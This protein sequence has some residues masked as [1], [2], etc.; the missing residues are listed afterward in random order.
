MKFPSFLFAFL[1][2]LALGAHA[3]TYT[4]I[5]GNWTGLWSSDSGTSNRFFI[6]VY[7]SG[8]SYAGALDNLDTG[9]N[10]WP[11]S[12]I[13]FTAPSVVNMTF[14][15]MGYSYTGVVNGAFTQ[16]SGNWIQGQQTWPITFIRNPGVND[17]LACTNIDA[18]GSLPYRLFVPS[19][20]TGTQSYPLILFLHGRG[21]RG[22]D[23]TNQLCG[24]TGEL[25]LVFNENQASHPSFVAAPQCPSDTEWTNS[26]MHQQ[27]LDL[28]TSLKSQ[29]NIDSNRVYITGLSMGGN[30]TWHL[31]SH[32]TSLFASGVPMSGETY[33][34][35]PDSVLPVPVWVFH[36]LSD[37]TVA[38]TNSQVMVSGM[39]ALGGSPIYT[40]YQYGGHSIW[41][42]SYATPLL[43]EW[44]LSQ[45]RGAV[46]SNN[47]APFLQ[48][49]YPY[50]GL[51]Y[52]TS[53][54]NL[55]LNGTAG[56]SLAGV[57]QIGWT[58]NRT[59]SG[60]AIGTTNWSAPNVSL[61]TG[62][63]LITVI[64]TGASWVTQ[65]YGQ[66]TFNS[67]IW[68]YQGP[69]LSL[70]ASNGIATLTWTGGSPPYYL[71]QCTNLAFGQW[72]TLSTNSSSS[73]Q[74]GLSSSPVF[75]RVRCQ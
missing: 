39:R 38:V 75:F 23:N 70:R 73:A 72:Q 41:S 36:S 17:F 31:L 14:S 42:A 6:K 54:T 51:S 10:N 4:N 21:E 19:N 58:N 29:Y 57:S 35:T 27:L 40:E 1:V 11:A 47:V 64:A 30:G 48:V 26:P 52:L 65:Y 61:Q 67:S 13:T 28:L 68:S 32:D 33:T 18:I 59:S 62:T 49:S 53:K 24:E 43:Y 37:P 20:Y 5:A 60:I 50:S 3:I 15:S 46:S 12:S 34:S 69:V 66:T 44:L 71:E 2:L 9:D 55:S 22:S 74:V 63:N 7:G 56:N 25:A 45:R 16:M 8:S